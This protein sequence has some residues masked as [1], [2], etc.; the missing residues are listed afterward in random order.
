[1]P[2]PYAGIIQIRCK[3]L[4]GPLPGSQSTTP[5]DMFT[6]ATLLGKVNDYWEGEYTAAEKLTS[7][8]LAFSRISKSCQL[9]ILGTSGPGS[10]SV[11][12]S[13]PGAGAILLSR[14]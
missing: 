11:G 2:L 5:S 1:M 9:E 10:S 3:G 6:V 8:E 7:Y 14:T 13:I 12:P 4:P